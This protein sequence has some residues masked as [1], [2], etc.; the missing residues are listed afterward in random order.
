[1]SH[2]RSQQ[3]QCLS[4]CWCKCL[5]GEWVPSHD[6]YDTLLVDSKMAPPQEVDGRQRAAVQGWREH[7]ESLAWCE[8][9]VESNARLRQCFDHP[10]RACQ[11]WSR[12]AHFDLWVFCVIW[13]KERKGFIA[14]YYVSS[15]STRALKY[16]VESTHRLSPAAW[17][18]FP[19]KFSWVRVCWAPV[20]VSLN[21]IA[22][23]RDLDHIPVLCLSM[24]VL[25]RA[26]SVPKI[27]RPTRCGG[28]GG[29]GKQMKNYRW[30]PLENF[31]HSLIMQPSSLIIC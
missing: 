29:E 27:R 16:V 18:V 24:P 23:V 22:P 14:L 5:P 15:I 20:A 1:M 7:Y 12:L 28:K 3:H 26:Y 31:T 25:V 21:S 10:L 30:N 6:R 2:L 13:E 4:G 8:Q 19:V 11:G 9:P 17:R